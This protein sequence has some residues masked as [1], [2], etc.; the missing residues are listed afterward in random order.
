[1]GSPPV[2]AALEAAARRGVQVQVTMTRNSEWDSAF[3]ALRAAGVALHTYPDSSTALYIHAKTIVVDGRQAFV[4]SENFSTAS[5]DR[6]RELGLVTSAPGIVSG[7][8][9]VLARDWSGA[10]PWSG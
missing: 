3:D 9:A 10:T 5:L 2:S 4:G 6:N 1:M 7:V 8:A